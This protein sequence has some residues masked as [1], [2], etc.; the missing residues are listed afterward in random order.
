MREG[1][2]IQPLKTLALV[3][4]LASLVVLGGC[5]TSGNDDE[6]A[7]EASSAQQTHALERHEPVPWV[8]AWLRV[9]R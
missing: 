2:M 1:R 5:G 3:V 4:L 9:L 7:D 6:I 8:H